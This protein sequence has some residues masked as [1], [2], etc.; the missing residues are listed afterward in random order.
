MKIIGITGGTGCGKTTAL[1]VL[2]ELGAYCIDCDAVYHTLLDNC[3]EMRNEIIAAFPSCAPTGVFDRK[4]LGKLVF[5]DPAL[6]QQLN[7]ITYGYIFAKVNYLLDQADCAG[8]HAAAIDAIGLLESGLSLLCHTTVAITA[9]DEKRL[10]RLIAREHISP[11][12]AQARMD[13]Q[14]SNEAFSSMC[15][16]TLCNDTTEAAFREACQELFQQLLHERSFHC[17]RE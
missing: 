17:E 7:E 5:A 12:Y 14:R 16:H 4:E 9:P 11:T 1:H 2:Q 6:L 13:A 15:R 3:P 10:E 8:Y